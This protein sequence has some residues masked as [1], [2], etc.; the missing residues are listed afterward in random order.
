MRPTVRTSRPAFVA[1]SIAAVRPFVIGKDHRRRA[2]R[3]ERIEQ[4]HLGG[5]VVLDRRVVVHVVAAEIGE[6]APPKAARRR[7]ALVEAVAGSF[8]RRMGDAGIGEFGEQLVQRYRIGRGQRTV[9]VRGPA[10]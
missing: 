10:P 6:G 4:A 3:Q 9:V 7:G 1:A 8:H 2:L 5:H